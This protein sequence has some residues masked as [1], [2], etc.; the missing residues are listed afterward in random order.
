MDTRVK[1]VREDPEVG[2]GSCSTFDECYT[3]EELSAWLDD[4]RIGSTEEAVKEC[5]WTWK[6]QQEVWNDREAGMY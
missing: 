2:K 3:D 1:A 4:R 6:I 5:R